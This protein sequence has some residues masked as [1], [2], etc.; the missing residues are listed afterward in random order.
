MSP[1]PQSRSTGAF[2]SMCVVGFVCVLGLGML[3]PVM[4]KHAQDLGLSGG[5]IGVVGGVFWVPAVVLRP[6][7]GLGLDGRGRRP[8]LRAGLALTLICGLCYPL[9]H[10]LVGLLAIR[11]THGVGFAMASSAMATMVSD[12]AP[13]ARANET[14]SYYWMAAFAGYAIGPGTG[15]WLFASGHVDLVFLT[16][17]A[18]HAVALVISLVLVEPP[19]AP[20][21]PTH[22][23][24]RNGILHRAAFRPAL[25]MAFVSLAAASAETFV[26]LVMRERQLGSAVSFFALFA[27]ALLV[28]NLGAGKLADRGARR[29]LII[30]GTVCCAVAMVLITAGQTVA[31]LRV[32]ALLIGLGWGT[33]YPGVFAQTMDQ[34]VESEKGRAVCTLTAAGDLAFGASLFVAGALVRHGGIHATFSTAAVLA[35]I[36]AVA[37]VPLGR[38]RPG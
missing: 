14:M 33:V 21:P 38:P 12:A 32:A 5:E 3:V 20:S 6:L 26:P 29:S 37:A 10:G 36:G 1:D 30:A 27:L 34:I 11:L 22:T 35:A 23:F 18:A 7:I 16:V 9:A 8:F 17:A 13:R 31:V 24:A 25:A 28:S 2:I 4:P 19:R 15:E